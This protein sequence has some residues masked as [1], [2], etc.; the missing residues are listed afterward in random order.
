MGLYERF[1]GTEDPKIA[2]HAWMAALGELERTLMSGAEVTAAFGLDAGAQAEAATLFGRI[3]TPV[4]SISVGGLVTLT[5]IGASFDSTGVSQG[6]GW[7]R[8]ERGGISQIEFRVRVNKV[9]GGTQTWQ[10]WNETDGTEVASIAD[11]GATGV[12]ELTVVQSFDP[13]LALGVR[14]LRVRAMSTTAADDP[15]YFGASIGIRRIGKMTAN[16]LHEVL[17]LAEDGAKYATV[18]SLKAR[19]G[20]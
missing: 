10:L 9:G 8:V 11:A 14:S 2:V 4:E 6:L 3:V 15:V 20:V 7:C 16:E 5:N 1:L 19:L 18:T 12:K 13:P 17:L